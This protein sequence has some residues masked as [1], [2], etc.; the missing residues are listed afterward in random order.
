M[1]T[2][3]KLALRWSTCISVVR[4]GR[5]STLVGTGTWS[6]CCSF[7][8]RVVLEG[9]L[10]L[11]PQVWG[12]HF[13]QVHPWSSPLP[14]G[15]EDVHQSCLWACKSSTKCNTFALNCGAS[16]QF[17]RLI[18]LLLQSLRIFRLVIFYSTFDI[19][20]FFTLKGL[21]R[22]FSIYFSSDPKRVW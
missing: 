5:V 16:H 6:A 11:L 8:T 17:T 12:K 13:L 21:R 20:G 19:S 22:K 18:S 4:A 14:F 7:H 15:E 3:L 10:A 9:T 1:V 2:L